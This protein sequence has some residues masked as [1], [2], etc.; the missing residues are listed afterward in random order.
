MHGSVF[1]EHYPRNWV[2][3]ARASTGYELTLSDGLIS[4]K[5]SLQGNSYLQV[6]AP[7]SHGS[8][9]GGLFD[10]N[11]RLIGI[12]TLMDTSGQALN[13]A[14][15]AELIAEMP[16]RNTL[17][18]EPASRASAPEPPTPSASANVGDSRWLYLAEEKGSTY[19][20]D[21]KSAR[22]AG[23]NITGWIKEAP[24]MASWVEDGKEIRYH[25]QFLNVSFFC[26]TREMEIAESY[27]TNN[28]GVQ[29]A[30]RGLI[31]R[32]SVSPNSSYDPVIDAVCAQ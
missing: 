11:G 20:L 16:A 21:K 26:A 19:Y 27:I 15:P 22:V 9:G 10:G 3:F 30:T 32:F 5:R 8:S 7:I 17:D 13:F 14:I 28:Q 12:T 29:L 25:E 23:T 6:T 2:S 4:G 18:T 24:I 1:D 31:E